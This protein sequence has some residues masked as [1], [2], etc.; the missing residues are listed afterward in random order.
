MDLTVYHL[1]ACDTCR[2]ALAALAE[3]R[4]RLVDIRKDGIPRA[5]LEGW[6]AALG[7]EVLVNRRGTTWR[8][9]SEAERARP[10]LDLL[11]DHPSLMKRP[12]IV[13]AGAVHAGWTPEVRAALGL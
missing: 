2:K 8:G 10:A 3:R 13:A 4:P 1:P 7:A 12:V 6:L 11:A 5:V 9:L